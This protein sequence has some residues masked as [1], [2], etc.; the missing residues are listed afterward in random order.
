MLKEN[1][2]GEKVYFTFVFSYN[3]Y[4]KIL[5]YFVVINCYVFVFDFVLYY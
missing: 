4:V 1:V 5:R 2:K 3:F